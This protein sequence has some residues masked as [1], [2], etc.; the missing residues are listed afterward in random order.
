MESEDLFRSRHLD[1]C[2]GHKLQSS[3]SALSMTEG[4][5]QILCFYSCLSP[6]T[7]RHAP[8]LPAILVCTHKPPSVCSHQA[9]TWPESFN[10]R[11]A[12]ST[13]SKGCCFPP[14]KKYNADHH[15]HYYFLH[16]Y[17]THFHFFHLIYL[18]TYLTI[19]IYWGGGYI[20][21][22]RPEDNVKEFIFSS[23]HVSLEE[24]I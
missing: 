15:R 6:V 9:S 7:Q 13:S 5:E 23:H 11:A 24:C 16:W 20:Q 21:V 14:P 22:W 10:S 12:S 19:Y 18:L 8:W 17:L 3:A 2:V 1:V 4:R